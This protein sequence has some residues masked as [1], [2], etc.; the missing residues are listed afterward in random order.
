L[1]CI[2]LS[3]V[4]TYAGFEIFAPV[5]VPPAMRGKWVVVEGKGL[6]G[7]SVEFSAEGGMIGARPVE[8]GWVTIEGR[9]EV[10]GNLF[11]V[12]SVRGAPGWATI[13]QEIIELTDRWLVL[14]DSEGEALIMQRASP[15]PTTV[16]EAR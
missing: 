14:Q 4:A 11:R 8:A 15:D 3:G 13:P 5:R 6:D 12:V 16:G 1:A 9:V 2:A 10:R 7:A